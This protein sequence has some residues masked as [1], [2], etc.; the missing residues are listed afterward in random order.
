[1]AGANTGKHCRSHIERLD[2]TFPLSIL[3]SVEPLYEDAEDC[4]ALMVFERD[5]FFQVRFGPRVAGRRRKSSRGR[6]QV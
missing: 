4:S 1:M 5:F 3:P 6:N 2:W